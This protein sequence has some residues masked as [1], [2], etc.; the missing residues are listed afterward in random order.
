MGINQSGPRLL[1]LGGSFDPV[2]AGHL[3]LAHSL[4][5]QLRP[6]QLRIIPAGQPWQKNALTA[7][8][9][10]RVSMLK[11]AFETWTLCPVMIDEQEIQR[12]KQQQVNYT[13]D[14]LRALR[15][16][17]GSQ[18]SIS[19]AMGADQLQN[20]HTWRQWRE[21]FD[22]A[23]LCAAARPG[24]SLEIAAPEVAQEWRRRA[25]SALTIQNTPCGGSFLEP[26]LA[27]D[28]SA[29]QLRAGL[30]QHNPTMRSLVPHKVLDYIQQ[31]S[32]Y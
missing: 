20:L 6:H 14:T 28:V 2:H 31:H 30:H 18:A 8:S 11:L 23:H 25:S 17:S 32:I 15:Q 9:E 24:F 16:E 26:E 21:L 1:V 22:L 10:Q 29:T 7:T 4:C 27:V 3:A 5:L 19:F 13:V 12:A